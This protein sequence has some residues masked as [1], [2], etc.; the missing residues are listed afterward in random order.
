[1]NEVNT[2]PGSLARYLWVGPPCPSPTCSR[3]CSLKPDSAPHTPTRRP[4]P[5]ARS[6][7]RQVRSPANWAE[8]LGGPRAPAPPRG[9]GLVEIRPHWTFLTGPLLV[10]ICWPLGS[11][12]RWISV[13][14]Y[15]G[16]RSLGRGP[17]GRR[18]LRLGR[19]PGWCRWR[20]TGLDPTSQ[21]VIERWGAAAAPGTGNHA[22]GHRRGERLPVAVPPRRRHRQHGAGDRGGRRSCSVG[23]RTT[24]PV[25][26][27]RVISRRLLLDVP[28]PG[29]L[30]GLSAAGGLLRM[31]PT[32]RCIRRSMRPATRRCRR[33][34]PPA[35]P[36]SPTGGGRW[37]QDGTGPRRSRQTRPRSSGPRIPPVGQPAG[38]PAES[39]AGVETSKSWARLRGSRSSGRARV[40]GII[41]DERRPAATEAHAVGFP[42]RPRGEPWPAQQGCPR[43]LDDVVLASPTRS[44]TD[45]R[46]RR[47]ALEPPGRRTLEVAQG[48]SLGPSRPP[49]PRCPE[50]RGDRARWRGWRSRS[51]TH[52]PACLPRTPGDPSAPTGTPT[53]CSALLAESVYCLGVGPV[54]PKTSASATAVAAVDASPEPNGRVVADGQRCLPRRGTGKGCHRSDQ[55]GPCRLHGSPGSPGRAEYR[56]AV[57]A[58]ASN[59]AEDTVRCGRSVG[60]NSTVTPRPMA[61][62]RAR[63]RL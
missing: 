54:T 45:Y 6:S 33:R 8:A 62:G 49:R 19:P 56:V 60:A 58:E 57:S 18:S 2:V 38:R 40:G 50:G 7:V 35:M 52:G 3:T 10:S 41:V 31:H 42:R 1:M 30:S 17:G 61:M 23:S 55:A 12:W 28:P 16:G 22:G 21:R 36:A 43:S 32:S 47:L 20:P 29:L 26:L 51:A 44:R 34:P 4:G 46:R 25:I 63:P 48:P 11:A 59:A 27:Q 5:M 39:S 53:R 15:V 24:K 14:Q 13:P 37:P 9:K